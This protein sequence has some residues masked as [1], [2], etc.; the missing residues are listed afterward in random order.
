MSDA[1]TYP[2]SL[3]HSPVGGLL[4]A[5]Q[6]EATTATPSPLLQFVACHGLP[7]LVRL[8]LNPAQGHELVCFA[9]DSLKAVLGMRGRAPQ[10]DICRI[11]LDLEMI[12]L[13]VMAIH[14]V[15]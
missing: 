8:L 1:R 5:H 12:E 7:A 9:V 3:H 15:P 2:Q 10:N 14:E 6:V 13:L 11:L 4:S